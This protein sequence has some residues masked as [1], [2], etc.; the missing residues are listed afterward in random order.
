MIGKV[1]PRIRIRRRNRSDRRNGPVGSTLGSSWELSVV[2]RRRQ[3]ADLPKRALGNTGFEVTTLAYGAM[4][5]RGAPRG[6]QLSDEEA[7]ALLNTVLDV[8]INLIDTSIDYG[9][10]EERIG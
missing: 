8:G 5:L 7:G 3:M 6:P 2:L 4:E 1:L 9:L 10:S